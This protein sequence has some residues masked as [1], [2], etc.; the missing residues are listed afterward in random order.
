MPPATRLNT[1]PLKA[2]FGVDITGIDVTTAPRD[3]LDEIVTLFHRHGA[4]VVRD[5]KLSPQQQVEFTKLFGTPAD[6]P[7]K[8]YTV[9]DCPDVFVISN[10]I[11]DGRRI[12]DADAGTGWH[13]DMSY[14]RYPG[15]CTLLH[16]LE[17][18]AEGSD[19][20]LADLCAAWDALPPARQKEL[21]PLV[22]HHS[23]Q[24]LA[25]AKS[26]GLTEHQKQTLPDVFHRL[27]RKHPS[28]GRPALRPAAR[29]AIGIVDMPNPQG[30][31]LLKEL[32]AFVTQERFL[33]SHKWRVGDL[34]VWDNNCTLHRGTPFDK[35]RYI[36]HVNRTWVQSPPEHYRN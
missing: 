29:G 2:N 36:R 4:V 25:R 34:L 6:N 35:D 28:D 16:A 19:T 33:Y 15:Q 26:Y 14:D 13:F 30:T 1:R 23:Y 18:P 32:V 21:E 24:E 12:G 20:L 22:V 9:P 5:Q 31:D 8:E 17:V 10:K 27:V 7:R 3:I 11:V